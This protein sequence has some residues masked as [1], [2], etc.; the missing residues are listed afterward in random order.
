VGKQVVL[1]LQVS[2]EPAE[3]TGDRQTLLFRIIQEA[4]SNAMIHAR[5]SLITVELNYDAGRLTAAVRD[6]GSGFDSGKVTDLSKAGLGLMNMKLR[7][8]LLGG[9]LFVQST[10][11]QGTSISLTVDVKPKNT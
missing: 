3:L 6:N 2:G 7:T 5:A 4:M 8:R 11:G 9:Q 1:R 10:P